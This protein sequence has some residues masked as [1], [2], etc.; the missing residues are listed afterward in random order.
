MNMQ[1]TL[2]TPEEGLKKLLEK[3]GVQAP[4][5]TLGEK[6]LTV[7]GVQIPLFPWRFERRFTEMKRMLTDGTLGAVCSIRAMRT[8]GRDESLQEIL[9]REI[10]LCQ[11]WADKPVSQVFCVENGQCAN[12]IL[13]FE[14]NA[15]CILEA[16][17]TLSEGAEP[18][19]RHEVTTDHGMCGDQAIDTLVHQQSVYE[20]VEGKPGAAY[21]DVDFE[22]YGLTPAQVAL[23][24]CAFSILSGE[25][26]AAR[27]R[28]Q[29][30]RIRSILSAAAQSAQTRAVAI[31]RKEESL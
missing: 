28:A 21:T 19:E 13:R 11:W 7:N 25:T 30:A 27:A 31:P 2:K 17:S 23:T 5:F 22:L 14:G 20:F 1:N 29:D 4:S 8:A 18:A 6:T 12:L 9:Y 26:D 10:D 15:T 16:A 24:R 3:Y